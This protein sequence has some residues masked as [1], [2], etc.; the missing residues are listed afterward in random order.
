[1]SEYYL[2]DGNFL[3]PV[4]HVDRERKEL[5]CVATRIGTLPDFVWPLREDEPL[6]ANFVP[7]EKVEEEDGVVRF[8]RLGPKAAA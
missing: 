4:Y 2:R 6:P 5:R 7:V 1:M 8:R 3:Q